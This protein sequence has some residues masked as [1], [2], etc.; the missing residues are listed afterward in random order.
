MSINTTSTSD[1]IAT[2][3]PTSSSAQAA[4][5]EKGAQ[6]YE[7][8]PAALPDPAVIARLANEFFAALPGAAVPADAT[9]S[10]PSPGEVDL[11][12]IS[13]AAPRAAVPDHQREMF[14][15]PAVLNPRSVP[16][17]PQPPLSP[18]TGALN[19]ADF[20]AIAA[21]LAGATPLVPQVSAAAPPSAIPGSSSSVDG[22]TGGP[23]AAAPQFPPAGEMYSFPG[24]PAMPSS[25][26]T[27][28]P[29][30]A[31]LAAAPA[32]PSAVAPGVPI[33]P[34][35]DSVVGGRSDPWAAAPNFPA[36]NEMFS[37]PRV[38]GMSVPGV[39]EAIASQPN[40]PAAQ[41]VPGAI[42]A[43]P[44][45]VPL[46]NAPESIPGIPKSAPSVA[47][48]EATT[49]SADAEKAVYLTAPKFPAVSEMFSF[50]GVPGAQSPPGVPVLPSSIPTKPPTESDLRALPSALA[51]TSASTAQV[52]GFRA[53]TIPGSSGGVSDAKRTAPPQAAS[54]PP[55]VESVELR[56]DLAPAELGVAKRPLDPRLIRQDFPILQE[57]VHGRQLIWLDNAATTQK[58]NA[59][60]DRLLY[61]Y[62]HENSNIHRAAHTLAARATDAYESAREKTRRFLNASSTREIVFVRGTTEG[63]NLV[64][65]SWGQRNVQKD[66]EVVITWLEHHANIVP[67]QQL[68]SEKGARLRVAPVNDRGEVILEEYEKLL[69]PRT[70]IVSFSQVSNA[71]GTITPARE[72][73]EMAHRYG[74]RVLVDGAQAVSHMR[75]DVQALDCDFYVFSGHKI[76]APTGIGIVYGKVDLLDT[77]PPWHG[78]GNMIVDVTFEKT[79]YQKAP[80]R[81]EAGTGNIADAVGLGA[82]LDY[83][84]QIGMESIAAYEHELLTYAT[85]GLLTVPGLRLIGT[86]REKAGV[87]SFVLDDVRTEDV[88]VALNQEGI[89][90]RAGHHCAQPILR[91]MG[92]EATVRPSLALYSTYEEIDALVSALLRIQA[93]R[94]HRGR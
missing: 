53:T 73:V 5:Q 51:G 33:P 4:A 49:E 59:V 82:A 62:R 58:P 3:S 30:G 1:R 36:Q 91:R 87:M 14:S 15:F 12:A 64:A 16:G 56:P 10:P 42:P 78:G 22:E 50:P 26:P 13:G 8:M 65:K 94:G 34:T 71:L 68:C 84:E 32:S 75:V 2:D 6:Q 39:P 89:A 63:I 61:F 47:I 81:F 17:L 31:D 29:S 69:G 52:P 85:A 23:W 7:G 83:V 67:W 88:G 66:D 24:V 76:F 92:V 19:E 11:R 70:R 38:P 37:F 40:L 55:G 74:A 79:T 25:P 9:V 48:P 20:R 72:M 57:R 90:V 27:A 35:G 93:G 60:I 54:L 86:A 77:M 45:A 43:A 18:P 41:S 80:A 28:P 46:T 21:S 44:P